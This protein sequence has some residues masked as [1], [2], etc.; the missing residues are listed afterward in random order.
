MADIGELSLSEAIDPHSGSL[1]AACAHGKK[2]PIK[3]RYKE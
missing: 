3:F 2:K 1:A